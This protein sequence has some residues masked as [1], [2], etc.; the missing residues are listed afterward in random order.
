[1][2][3]HAI[4]LAAKDKNKRSVAW[5]KIYD[6]RRLKERKTMTEPTLC[7]GYTK[8]DQKA[9]YGTFTEKMLLCDQNLESACIL[10]NYVYL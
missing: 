10:R 2:A 3:N 8:G 7:S 4:T 5:T 1:M 6:D 9:L